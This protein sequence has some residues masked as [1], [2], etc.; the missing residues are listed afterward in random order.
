MC[1]YLCVGVY[2]R[3]VEVIC[4]FLSVVVGFSVF[5][6]F[7]NYHLFYVR[8]KAVQLNTF[9]IDYENKTIVKHSKDKSGFDSMR[10][11]ISWESVQLIRCNILSG[12]FLYF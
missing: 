1:V 3:E 10:N 12:I 2:E 9:H 8:P 11:E 5:G 4:V 7:N 6:F